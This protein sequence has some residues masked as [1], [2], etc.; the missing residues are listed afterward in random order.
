VEIISVHVA[1]SA[2]KMVSPVVQSTG[3]GKTMQYVKQEFINSGG[4]SRRFGLCCAMKLWAPPCM[5]RRSS[6]SWL[7]GAKEGVVKC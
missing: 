5:L 7:H 6:W 2:R 1:E 4:G 3:Q